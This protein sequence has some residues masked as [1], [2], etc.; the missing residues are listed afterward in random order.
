MLWAAEGVNHHVCA[1]L[2]RTRKVNAVSQIG[3]LI[4]HYTA[5]LTAGIFRNANPYIITIDMY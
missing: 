5:P 3:G 2:T 4:L 1:R